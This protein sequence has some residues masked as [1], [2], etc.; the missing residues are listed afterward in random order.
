MIVKDAVTHDAVLAAIHGA[1]T[2]GLLRDAF[3]FDVYKPKQTVAGMAPDEK[4]FALR[5]TLASNDATLTD[6]QI[7]AC[8]QAIVREV[9][10]R[11]GARLR[12]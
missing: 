12:G 9:A 3:L 1:S 5:L 2:G 10:G 11:T 8:V 7:E 4:S 6:E